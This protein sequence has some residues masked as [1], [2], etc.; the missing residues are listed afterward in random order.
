VA[1]TE[2][3]PTLI[4]TCPSSKMLLLT[5]PSVLGD[6]KPCDHDEMSDQNEPII[7]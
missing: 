5:T 6:K 3:V 2:G 7:R 1:V 4:P